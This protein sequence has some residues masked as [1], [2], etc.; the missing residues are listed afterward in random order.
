[1]NAET[2]VRAADNLRIWNDVSKTDPRHTKKVNQR[3]G[4]TAISAH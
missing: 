1:M 4:F 2:N 3:G